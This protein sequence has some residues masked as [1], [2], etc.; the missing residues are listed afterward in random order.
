MDKWRVNRTVCWRQK[1]SCRQNVVYSLL[2][3]HTAHTHRLFLAR[4]VNSVERSTFCCWKR[5]WNACMMWI[6]H[7]RIR[8]LNEIN[9]QQM[10]TYRSTARNRQVKV[11]RFHNFTCIFD[12]F[13]CLSCNG[14]WIHSILTYNTNMIYFMDNIWILNATRTGV[15]SRLRYL[16]NIIIWAIKMDIIL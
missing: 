8:Y 10:S 5:D 3:A 9:Q 12:Y 1:R 13:M 16:R 14:L 15:R 11:L 7:R 4:I 6:K 2:I